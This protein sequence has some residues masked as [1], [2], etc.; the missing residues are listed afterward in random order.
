MG[1]LKAAAFL[2]DVLQVHPGPMIAE[3]LASYI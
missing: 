3:T 1:T 2:A